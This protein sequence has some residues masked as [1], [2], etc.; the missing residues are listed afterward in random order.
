MAITID[1]VTLQPVRAVPQPAAA[2]VAAPPV[3]V[4][5]SARSSRRDQKEERGKQSLSFRAVLDAAAAGQVKLDAVQPETVKPDVPPRPT[6][7]PK[8]NP[9]ELNGGDSSILLDAAYGRRADSGARIHLA[10]TSR[11][12]QAFFA[13][14]RTFA[15]PGE[16]LELTV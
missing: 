6:K 4:A 2:F 5:D 9:A 8:G 14:T 1:A 13:D 16:S 12:A 10:A 7:L 3:V 11:Y 15:R